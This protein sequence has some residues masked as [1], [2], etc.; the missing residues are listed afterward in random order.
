M[1]TSWIRLVQEKSFNIFF[2]Y[3]HR[4]KIL[5]SSYEHLSTNFEKAKQ[6]AMLPFRS[7]NQST[8]TFKQMLRYSCYITTLNCCVRILLL[9]P[10]T[11]YNQSL[12][13]GN[14]LFFY[15]T[16]Y[17]EKKNRFQCILMMSHNISSVETDNL[18]SH[19]QTSCVIA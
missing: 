9:P 15:L 19:G 18:Y 10:E 12:Q 17:S 8:C 5:T 11:I 3:W 7:S 1:F 13:L 2:Y 16:L 4:L 6:I 14:I